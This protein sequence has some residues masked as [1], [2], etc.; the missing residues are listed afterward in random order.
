[1]GFKIAAAASEEP[2]YLNTLPQGSQKGGNAAGTNATEQDKAANVTALLNEE[3]GPVKVNEVVVAVTGSSANLDAV[4]QRAGR[5]PRGGEEEDDQSSGIF[6]ET[7]V[8]AVDEV[9]VSAPP[10]ISP[11]S[12]ETDD[13][14]LSNPHTAVFDLDRLFT[15]TAAQ[16]SVPS[17]PDVLHVDFFDPS[18]RGRGLDLA[19]PSPSSLA[20]ELQGGDST[21]WAMPDNYD[22][23]TPY[24]DGVSP[25]ADEYTYSTTT[26]TY[27]SDDDL[28]LAAGSPS[29]SKP[30]A[31]GSGSIIPGASV[32]GAG[33]P[34]PN[35]PAAGGA[36]ASL[37]GSDGMGGCRVGF[38]MTNGSC[39][40]P[41]DMLPNFCFN[42]GQCYLI[43]TMGVFC[44]TNE[45]CVTLTA[46][47]L[48][49]SFRCNVQDYIWHKGAR[50]ESV[51]T[52]FQVMCLTVGTS[53]LVLLLLFMI[54]VCFAKKL[55]VLKTEN[56]KLRKR[57]HPGAADLLPSSHSVFGCGTL[58][59][60]MLKIGGESL[61]PELL[62]GSCSKYRPSSEQHNDNFSLSTIAEG[63]H[64]NVRKLC[65]TPPNVPHAR[66]LAYYDNIICQK[67]MSRYTWECKTKEE[68]DCEDDPHSQNK[69]EDPVK[70]PPKEDD[71]LNIHNSLTPKHE[72]HKVLGEDNSSEVNSL[73]NNMM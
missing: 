64:P 21:S 18:S 2:G 36:P 31:P 23:L 22:Y 28:R 44:R 40:S 54:V 55:H 33:A 16:P 39:R 65:D 56:K 32:P 34:V 6:G 13:L 27:E 29:R 11:D 30:R 73:Q 59:P 51:V 46:S 62:P 71:S 37:D 24:E 7:L 8:P 61:G 14:L 26:D 45:G 68:S 25:T 43:E 35:V 49:L 47:L 9:A 66:A 53:A 57:R 20:H 19:P 58:L 67:T 63:S 70:A 48:S 12:A 17:N 5:T 60:S 50:C 10:R 38:Q 1:M 3:E 15:T 4:T 72:N 69:L 41:C 52:E 42:G